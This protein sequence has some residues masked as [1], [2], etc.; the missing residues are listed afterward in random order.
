MGITQSANIDSVVK[1]DVFLTTSGRK[2]GLDL[3][4]F[5]NQFLKGFF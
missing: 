2:E 5:Q 1:T 3:Y 4:G